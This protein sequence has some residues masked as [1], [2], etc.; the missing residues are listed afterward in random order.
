MTSAWP[1]SVCCGGHSV[2]PLQWPEFR[3]RG[4]SSRPASQ[5][6]T[7]T[8]CHSFP[9][10]PGS[11][12]SA[13]WWPGRGWRAP[14]VKLTS[15]LT[16]CSI[17]RQSAKHKSSLYKVKGKSR[18]YKAKGKSRLYKAKGKSR[19]YKATGKS[20]RL[21]KAKCKT[22]LYKAKGRSRLYK[23]KGKSRLYSIQGYGQE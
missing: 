10:S 8:S 15:R 3:H 2:C 7:L 22:R 12:R 17:G 23:A 16:Y 18:L 9:R 19:L 6:G 14:S 1:A 11:P 13:S 5:W 20:I 21:C 4:S